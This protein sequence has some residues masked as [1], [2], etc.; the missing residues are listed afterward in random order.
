MST[1]QMREAFEDW[2]GSA[3]LTRTTFGDCEN[4]F[5]DGQWS[6]WQA[7]LNQPAAPAPKGLEPVAWIDTQDLALM[8]KTGRGGIVWHHEQEGYAQTQLYAADGPVVSWRDWQE[9]LRECDDLD[10]RCAE[11]M[12]AG[13]QQAL[14][15][16]ALE[17]KLAAATYGRAVPSD[18]GVNAEPAS[19]PKTEDRYSVAKASGSRYAYVVDSLGVRAP[20]RFNI[21]KGGGWT[22]AD[23]LRDRLNGINAAA[24]GAQEGKP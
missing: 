22:Q 3:N 1:E 6:A 18:F 24:R 5:V 10:R 13:N 23:E 19:E 20:T 21:F 9:K 16:A 11:Y 14:R 2:M 12:E 17:A 15:I 4:N 7:A 8:R